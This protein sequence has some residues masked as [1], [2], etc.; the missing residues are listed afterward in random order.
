MSDERRKQ[1]STDEL[2]PGEAR[3]SR[4]Y[5]QM[6][7]EL[8]SANLDK[9]VLTAARRAV[10]PAPRVSCLLL[11]HGNGLFLALPPPCW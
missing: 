7:E 9:A 5:E 1:R 10:E 4:L 11:H 6:K 8:P 2:P 3:L